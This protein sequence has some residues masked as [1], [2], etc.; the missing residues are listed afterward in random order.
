[1]RKH[2]QRKRRIIEEILDLEFIYQYA[3]NEE[4]LNHLKLQ[5]GYLNPF[6]ISYEN[7][8]KLRD[9]LYDNIF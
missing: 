6:N 4:L 1:M 5:Y 9:D 7:L 8:F 2:Q 3:E